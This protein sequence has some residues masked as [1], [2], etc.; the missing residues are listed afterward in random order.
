MEAKNTGVITNIEIQNELEN[1]R[2]DLEAQIDHLDRFIIDLTSHK[3]SLEN[4]NRQIEMLANA[5]T[6]ASKRG[7]FY[8]ALRM[9][10]ELLTKIF[11]SISKIENIKHSYHKEIDDVI[12]GK[13][14]LIAIDIRK[15]EEAL[16]SGEGDLVGFF[17]KLGNAMSNL[18]K[19][20]NANIKTNVDNDPT[21]KL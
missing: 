5:E 17:E 20:G 19:G 10:I 13:I 6:D 8:T 4:A 7:K 2:K 12:V 16:R 9:N 21:Y 18:S 1:R 3:L 14:K 15:I 11:D